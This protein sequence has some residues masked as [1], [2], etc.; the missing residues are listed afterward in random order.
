MKRGFWA[1]TL[2]ISLLITIAAAFYVLHQLQN[3]EIVSMTASDISSPPV[4]IDPPVVAPIEKVAEKPTEK[5]TEKAVKGDPV[6]V[7]ESVPVVEKKT[8]TNKRNILFAL[9]RPSAKSVA[10]VGDFNDWKPVPMI[11]KGKK[12]ELGVALEPGSYKYM[13]VVDKKQIRD[14]N[15]KT[16]EDGKSVITVMPLPSS[17]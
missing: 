5:Q 8:A 15:K 11:K 14:P 1:G 12:W 16:V 13:F 6:S 3:Q 9:P 2:I 10:L 4:V 17:K 7:K